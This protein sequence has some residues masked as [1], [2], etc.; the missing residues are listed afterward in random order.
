[1]KTIVGKSVH[2]E[3]DARKANLRL[4]PAHYKEFIKTESSIMMA[5]AMKFRHDYRRKE[6]PYVV[7]NYFDDLYNV[8]IGYHEDPRDGNGVLRA[9]TTKQLRS[10][11]MQRTIRAL[12]ALTCEKN[13]EKN[14]SRYPCV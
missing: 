5:N 6:M 2:R 9:R 14:I 10:W 1:M 11:A 12:E 7:H 3:M 13:E 8:M 4:I